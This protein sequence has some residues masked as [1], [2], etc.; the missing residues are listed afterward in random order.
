MKT[1][2]ASIAAF[3]AAFL[4]LLGCASL[5]A[6]TYSLSRQK[7]LCPP[8][9]GL[10]NTQDALTHSVPTLRRQGYHADDLLEMPW[11]FC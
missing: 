4:L 2:K 6:A 8:A 3:G 11:G 10:E 1:G 5:Q 7:P 9:G